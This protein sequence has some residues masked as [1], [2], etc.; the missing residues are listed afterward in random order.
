MKD[1]FSFIKK[2]KWIIIASL[3]VAAALV[4]AFISGGSINNNKQAVVESTVSVLTST[5]QSQTTIESTL[6]TAAAKVSEPAATTVPQTKTVSESRAEASSAVQP[7]YS[8][9]STTATEKKTEPKP[10]TQP[11]TTEKREEKTTP[12]KPVCYFS[13]SCSTV[14]NHLDELDEDK[15]ELVPADGLIYPTTA[16]SFDNGESVFDIL[17]RVCRDNGIHLE[18]EWTPIYQSAYI[19][20]INNLYE[21]DCGPNSGWTYF[22][23]DEFMNYGVS[24]A[25]PKDGD[26]V[27]FRYSC[28]MGD[29]GFVS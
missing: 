19:S 6:G 9:Q 2:Y 16:V 23:N 20:G 5:V 26:N 22:I 25:F 4:I 7:S 14:L 8:A 17:Q 13:I 28:V 18:S 10:S 12:K 1:L 21:F 3:A 15:R 24:K 29:T 11:K 27:S